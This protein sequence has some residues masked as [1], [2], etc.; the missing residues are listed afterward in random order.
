[1]MNCRYLAVVAAL[2]CGLATSASAEVQVQGN[3]DGLRLLA[4]GDALSDVL[5]AL[6]AEL[7]V[8][9]RTAVPLS[10]EIKGAFSGPL[11]QV[12]AR[13]L[14][15]H[16][17]VIKMDRGQAEIIVLG[18]GGEIPVAAKLPVAG[19]GPGNGVMKRWR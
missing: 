2:A 4:S 9:F 7:P 10:G 3:L 14:S 18:P 17:Y 5:S 19:N 6:S 11:T 15:G 13:L 1:M 8:R 12:I 16:N